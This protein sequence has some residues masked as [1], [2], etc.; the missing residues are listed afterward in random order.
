[1]NVWPGLPLS[2]LIAQPS[3]HWTIFFHSFMKERHTEHTKCTMPCR[4]HG[5]RTKMISPL[6]SQRW[7]STWSFQSRGRTQLSIQISRQARIKGRQLRW[8]IQVRVKSW[9]YLN[10]DILFIKDFWPWFCFCFCFLSVAL[11][12]LISY[13]FGISVH[14]FLRQ[15]PHSLHTNPVPIR[16]WKLRKKANDLTSSEAYIFR[17]LLWFSTVVSLFLNRKRFYSL[18]H[19]LVNSL[20]NCWDYTHFPAYKVIS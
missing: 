8:L 17:E 4:S 12:I 9:F 11:F 6:I 2:S 14:F 15:I 20:F 10:A 16:N 19:A 1:M 5:E 7:N 18:E 13:V 3:F